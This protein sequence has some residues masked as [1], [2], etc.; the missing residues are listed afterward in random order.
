[1]LFVG[2]RPDVAYSAQDELA[3]GNPTPTPA[4]NEKQCESPESG[5]KIEKLNGKVK[6]IKEEETEYFQ[7]KAS[8]AITRL[9]TFQDS[10]DYEKI[11]DRKYL[12]SKDYSKTPK[13]IFSFDDNCRVVERRGPDRN[14]EWGVTRTVFSYSPGGVLKEHAIFDSEGRLLWKSL[15]TLDEK[16]RPIEENDTIQVHPEHFNPK[17]YD[18]YRNTRSVIKND[19]AGN[20]VEQVDYKYDGTL[21]ATY[22]R[23]YD[24]SNRLIRLTRVDDKGRN[25]DQSIYKYSQNGQL[26]EELKY[27]SFTY[28]GQRGEDLVPGTINSG[29]GMF[30]DGSRTT[31]E[32]DKSD[33]WVKK[34]KYDLSDGGKLSL[35]TVRTIT[36]Y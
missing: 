4:V 13:P 14:S 18:V 21:Y 25:I 2:C 10:G 8:K 22:Q 3:I 32:Y 36:Y 31:Y 17:R 6:A 27:S 1:M 28:S 19:E 26:L 9:V 16:D 5:W 29:Y 20:N 7:G 12:N 11:D 15:T 24:S 30:Q 23:A 35:V 33:N 34:T